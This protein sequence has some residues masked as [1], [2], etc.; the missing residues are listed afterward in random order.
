MTQNQLN[1]QV[2]IGVCYTAP[3]E[4]AAHDDGDK[5]CPGRTFCVVE[6]RPD[7]NSGV[8][9]CGL[10]GFLVGVTDDGVEPRFDELIDTSS[11][12]PFVVRLRFVKGATELR[13]TSYAFVV[14]TE[15]EKFARAIENRFRAELGA[16]GATGFDMHI[17][18][19][20]VQIGQT[21]V[22]VI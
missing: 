4:L 8:A 7:G 17:S 15:A 19:D 2:T 10:C 9:A 12:R 18:K 11:K 5:S 20:G 1:R 16:N 13:K 14:L 22:F 3:A 21:K 6:T